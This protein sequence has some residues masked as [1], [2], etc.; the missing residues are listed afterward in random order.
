MNQT[1]NIQVVKSANTFKALKVDWDSLYENAHEMTIFSSW[2]WM[3]TWWEVFADQFQRELHILCLYQNNEL[4][5][6]APFQI[7]LVYPKSLI[8]GKTLRFIGSGEAYED[9]ITSE[10][11]DFIV[12]QGFETTV[13]NCISEYLE[14][15]KKLWDFADFQF[16]Q[17]DALILQ[18]FTSS[19]TTIARSARQEGVRFYIPDYEIPD[20]YVQSLGKRWRKMFAKKS[21]LIER[22]GTVSIQSTETLEAVKPALTLLSDMHCSRWRAILGSC[23]FD[24]K[25]FYSFH[26]KILERLVPQKKAAIK[27]LMLND[28]PLAAYYI[29]EDKGQVHY[30]QS[31]FYAEHANRYSPLF[32]LVVNE[33]KTVIE[34]GKKFDFMYDDAAD[35]YKKRQYAASSEPMIRLFWT[36]QPLRLTIYN[37]SKSIKDKLSA[38]RE[39]MRNKNKEKRG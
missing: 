34:Q 35:S 28:K 39:T 17:P 5:G 11:Q 1:L 26:E 14:A 23:I 15:H 33:I 20:D 8:Q 12:K 4:V 38:I 22:D 9:S 21:R 37:K 10:S 32:L 7:D 2:E 3:F 27:T 25:R 30:Y 31:G 6:I 36:P 19:S 18:C 13:I 24:S 16:I 29:F